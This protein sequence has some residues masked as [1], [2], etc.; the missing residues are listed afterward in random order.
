MK[1]ALME[2]HLPGMVA[3]ERVGEWPVAFIWLQQLQAVEK[4]ER[5]VR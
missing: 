3:I 1:D 2:A 5:Y 4:K